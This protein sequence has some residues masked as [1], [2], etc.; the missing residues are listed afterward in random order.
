MTRNE[1]Q[2]PLDSGNQLNWNR[3]SVRLKQTGGSIVVGNKRQ[4]GYL[5]IRL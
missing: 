3:L 1:M 5:Y 4:D 2:C